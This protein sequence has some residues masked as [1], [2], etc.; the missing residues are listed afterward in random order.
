MGWGAPS[1]SAC[2][3][4]PG[5]EYVACVPDD[6]SGTVALVAFSAAH[7]GPLAP[8][9]CSAF[10]FAAGRGLA[11]LSEQGR[12]L[13]GLARPPNA[14]SACLPSCSSPPLPPAP[15]CRGPTLLQNIFPASPG[16]A[17]VGPQGPLASGQP[18]AFHITASL[19]VSSTRWDFGDGSPE[20]DIAG[21]DAT[22]HYVL[23]GRYPV[24]A[25]LALGVGSARL[26]AE[27]WVEAAPVALELMCLASVHSDETLK[28]GVRN[29]G[30]SGLEATY[31]IVAL[32]E[33]PAR[34]GA[35]LPLGLSRGGWGSPGW[36]HID[37]PS[38]CSLTPQWCIRSAPRTL[39]SSL[40]MGAATAWWWRR[41]PGCRHRSS[42]GP[43][44]GPPWLWWTVLP[45]S[46]SW[47]PA[48]PGAC[49]NA[50]GPRRGWEV[51]G[52]PQNAGVGMEHEHI[53]VSGGAVSSQP[54]WLWG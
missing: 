8:E 51:G 36:A 37:A 12:C 53:G 50:A 40:V 4:L 41:R 20:V 18:A 33:E 48:S 14:S 21:P 44:P 30:G 24:T 42:A 54:A 47:S 11:A 29:R 2:L 6:S 1:G 31:S 13:C 15:T 32:G 5:E 27:V 3:P 52:G 19:P 35:A 16:A 49:P 10:C 28:L 17:L 26:W 38:L 23:P 45:S 46:T 25:V 7:E 34:G 22:H 39:R 43:G 9:A